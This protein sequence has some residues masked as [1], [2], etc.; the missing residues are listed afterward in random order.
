MKE[1]SLADHSTMLSMHSRFR[2][3]ALCC[4][5]LVCACSPQ[6]PSPPPFSTSTNIPLR[7]S[8]P[9]VSTPEMTNIPLPMATQ[10]CMGYVSSW[11]C[12]C[13]DLP[14]EDIQIKTADQAGACEVTLPHAYRIHLPDDWYC[15]IAGVAGINLSCVTAY[16]QRIFVQAVSSELVVDDADKAINRFCEGEGCI[17]DPVVDPDEEIIEK[18]AITIGDKPVLRMLSKQEDTFLLRYFIKNGENLYV[19]QVEAKD[20]METKASSSLLEEAIESMEFVS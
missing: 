20:L 1:M 13:G 16:G 2:L 8:S 7:T 14:R 15:N 18:E 3:F 10:F 6:V 19:F 9:P 5:F 12:T 11:S 4:V 17:S